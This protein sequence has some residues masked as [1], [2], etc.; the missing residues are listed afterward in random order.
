MEEGGR[1]PVGG[2]PRFLTTQWSM[3]LRAGD[4]EDP[5]FQE[6]LADLCERYWYPIYAFVRRRGIRPEDAQDLV[7]GF[8][9]QLL[10]RGTLKAA[11]P[12]RGRFR[13]FILTAVKFHLSDERR[14]VAAQKRGG[15][16]QPMDLDSAEERYRMEA[17]PDATPERLFE[18]RWAMELLAHTRTRLREEIESSDHPERVRLAAFLTDAGGPRYKE[19]AEELG[20]SEAAVKVAVHRL[21]RRFGRLLREEVARTVEN[22][23]KVDDE[24]R[25]LLSV[26]E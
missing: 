15:A 2:D 14:R 3:V 13:S 12:H 11:D 1:L 7:Q 24:L 9:S 18:R 21:R 26:L 6:A 4:S 17:D 20:M 19:V 8:F 16:I 10:E 23:E 25:F 22:P 5:G